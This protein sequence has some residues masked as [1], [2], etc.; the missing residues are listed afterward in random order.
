MKT[1][2]LFSVNRLIKTE[3]LKNW[4]PNHFKCHSKWE[5]W[6]LQFLLIIWIYG[7]FHILHA[8][9]SWLS[10]KLQQIN[11]SKISLPSLR[12]WPVM[13][14]CHLQFKKSLWI[15]VEKQLLKKCVTRWNSVLLM[16]ER[17][18]LSIWTNLET[19]QNYN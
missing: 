7:G 3:K 10:K 18:Q 1:E 2:K 16:I 6:V 14:K 5:C 17:R 9:C 8:N 19:V 15:Y 11:L 13:L 4:M 12:I